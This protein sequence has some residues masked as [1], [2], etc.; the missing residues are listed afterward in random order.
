MRRFLALLAGGTALVVASALPALAE[1]L[2]VHVVPPGGRVIVQ[3][4]ADLLGEA[5]RAGDAEHVKFSAIDVAGEKFAQALGVETLKQPKTIQAIRVF[6][7]STQ[8][9][10]QD[11]VLL[12]VFTA[13]GRGT[14][15][16]AGWIE[17]DVGQLAP[18]GEVF[19]SRMLSMRSEW[20]RFYLPCKPLKAYAAGK[21]GVSLNMGFEPQSVE[22]ADVELI[23][24]GQARKTADLP[25]SHL[26]YQGREADAPWRKAAAERIDK[27]RR[28]DLRVH[29]VNADG[30][31]AV[32]AT[33][34][35]R[36]TRQAFPFASAVSSQWLVRQ[37]GADADRYRD[38][39]EKLFTH[40]TVD[41]A[42]C[43]IPWE[44]DRR[45]ALDSLQWLRDHGK[46][47]HGCHI[48]WP[49]INDGLPKGIVSVKAKPDE[50]RRLVM[51]HLDDK[52]AGCK[53]LVQEWN[54]VNELYSNRFFQES[55][56]ED[57][58]KAFVVDIFRRTRQ[59][60]PSLRLDINDYGDMANP[61]LA[62]IEGYLAWIQYLKDQR[63]PVDVVGLQCHFAQFLRSPEECLAIL[64]RFAAFGYPLHVTE[65]DINTPDELVQ[66]DYMR[67][68]M[69]VL[70]SHPAVE[71]ITLWGF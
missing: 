31:P 19:S 25:Q 68:I 48:I 35:V 18:D 45:L 42:T 10:K 41:W 40:V 16:R 9:V 51:A 36:M 20:Q 50:V 7:S 57:A 59:L 23:N 63:A 54:A 47:V 61:N 29:V 4:G 55:L 2:D 44:Q 52:V 38:M 58:G 5:N 33:I 56:G 26:T 53:G 66:A 11:D 65:L 13:R 69:T 28:G 60:D 21:L 34:E 46:Y 1:V 17:I 14:L 39:V 67:D 32:D 62:H 3:S 12:A 27:F 43:Q 70:Y 8:P 6:Y 22:I 15:G 64:D 24:Y 71:K 30:T 49:E 37:Q